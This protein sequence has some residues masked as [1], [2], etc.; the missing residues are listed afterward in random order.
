MTRSTAL[1]TWEHVFS[2]RWSLQLGAGTLL[3]GSLVTPIETAVLQPGFL[4]AVTLTH[5]VFESEGGARDGRPF[6]L[7]TYGLSF[8]TTRVDGDSRGYTALDF[9]FGLLVGTTFAGAVTPYA[10]ARLFGGPAFF[11]WNEGTS[12]TSVVGTDAYKYE[13][14]GGVVFTVGARDGT[15]HG[16][17]RAA[18][19]VEGAAW[20]EKSLR[21][22][23]SVSF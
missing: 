15:R 13:V 1:V 6:V 14:G 20:G 8:V 21:G 10:S 5:R 3:G 2:R 18:F 23:A 7:T 22:G 17:T 12:T 4:T 19:F 16:G 9:R 11:R